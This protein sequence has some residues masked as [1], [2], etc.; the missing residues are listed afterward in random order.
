M[1]KHINFE[2]DTRKPLKAI[3]NPTKFWENRS[4]AAD[5]RIAELER[6][7]AIAEKALELAT[8]YLDE[9]YKCTN[10]STPIDAA[11]IY[12]QD[13]IVKARK[14]LAEEKIREKQK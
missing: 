13:L 5:K 11:R 14:I 7:K 10:P 3:H 8:L 1:S 12:Q 6:E 2:K 4:L 9:A